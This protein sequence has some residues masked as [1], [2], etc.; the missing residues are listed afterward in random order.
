[1]EGVNTQGKN[2][3]NSA[4]GREG[5]R[6]GREG[7]KRGWK[8]GK[9]ARGGRGRGRE[10]RLD[11]PVTAGLRVWVRPGARCGGTS[12]QQGCCRTWGARLRAGGEIQ[13][14]G[15]AAGAG[16][17]CAGCAVTVGLSCD[18]ALLK[19]LMRPDVGVEARGTQDVV[20]AQRSGGEEQCIAASERPAP[21]AGRGQ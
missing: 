20:V 21:G 19:V 4:S 10:G 17:T 8:G 12:L 1:M 16:Q 11:S 18:L 15:G 5:G 14:G 2:M 7:G 9:G 3:P 6:E 13:A